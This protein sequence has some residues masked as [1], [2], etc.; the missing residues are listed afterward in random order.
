MKILFISLPEWGSV[1]KYIKDLCFMIKYIISLKPVVLLVYP[2]KIILNVIRPLI[3]VIFPKLIID[4]L[5]NGGDIKYLTTLVCVMAITTMILNLSYNIIQTIWSHYYNLLSSLTGVQHLCTNVYCDYQKIEDSKF[6][7]LQQKVKSNIRPT[8][9]LY[10]ISFF[11]ENVIQVVLYGYLIIRLH[12]SLLL[13]ILV[14]SIFNYLLGHFMN[15]ENYNYNHN[16]APISRRINYFFKIATDHIYGKDIRINQMNHLIKDKFSTASE[17]G[18][19]LTKIH[20]KKI[21]FLNIL[22]MILSFLGD[23]FVYIMI[24]LSY[25]ANKISLGTFSMYL[26]IIPNFMEY[27]KEVLHSADEFQFWAKNIDLLKEYQA[28]LTDKQK[29][30]KENRTLSDYSIEFQHVS[31]Q[32]PNS[33][34]YVLQDIHFKL[35]QG[36]SLAIVGVN[37][38]GKSTLIKLLCKLYEPTKGKIL[39]GGV[40]IRSISKEQYT[41]ILGVLLQDYKLFAFPI[42]ENIVLNQK[43]ERERLDR[44]IDLGMLKEKI[45]SL[46]NRENT[47]L[48][49]EFDD[50]GIELSGGELQKIALART[51]Y[52]KADIYL[53]DEANSA[54]DSLAEHQFY[55]N[56][57]DISKGKTAIYI[58][59]RLACARYCD[60][61]AV[62]E[63]GKLIEFGT[64]TELMEQET[65]YQSLFEKQASGY[66]QVGEEY[67][68]TGN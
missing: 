23:C 10:F 49:K 45:Q 8:D 50:N 66:L 40:D 17:Q 27:L 62:F 30:E 33:D 41:K 31:F 7:D 48:Y 22:G 53:F 65:F 68:K 2:I 34:K 15:Q 52:K 19:S 9:Y 51:I 12:F 64:H 39:I 18:I 46:P 28:V 3:F 38:A 24:I 11:I 29:E 47:T 26:T 58:S 13:G 57:K 36:E 54:L 56:I 63:K 21:T 55:Q 14:L 42:I 44:A 1:M 60:K 67:G 32:Y 61:I 35:N 16:L 43:E 4:E 20:H 25:L 37:G 6:L 59:H 5:T